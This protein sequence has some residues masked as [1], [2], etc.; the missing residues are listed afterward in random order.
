MKKNAPTLFYKIRKYYIATTPRHK[1]GKQL[2]RSASF[3]S[4]VL[5]KKS[6]EKYTFL[7]RVMEN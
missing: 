3:K 6:Q 2:H 1:S 4:G 5:H 7:K